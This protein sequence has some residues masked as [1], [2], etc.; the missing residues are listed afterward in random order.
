MEKKQKKFA[1]I[2]KPL[3]CPDCGKLLVKRINRYEVSFIGCTGF[4]ECKYTSTIEKPLGRVKMSVK[5]IM[6]KHYKDFSKS[7]FSRTSDAGY[8][9]QQEVAGYGDPY[10]NGGNVWGL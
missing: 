10:D 1:E 3:S 5:Q 2:E 8:A 9:T 6:G 7:S 4:P